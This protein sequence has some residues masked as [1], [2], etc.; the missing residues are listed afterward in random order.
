MNPINSMIDIHVALIYFI[1][2]INFF[3]LKKLC[4]NQRQFFD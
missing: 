3:M 1:G 4:C 2:V